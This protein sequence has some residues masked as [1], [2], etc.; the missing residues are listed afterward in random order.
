MRQLSVRL[1]L[2][3]SL[4]IWGRSP[5]FAKTVV[6][7]QDG[8]PTVASEPVSRATLMQAL[9]EDA[10]F[11]GID[12]LRDPSALANADLLVLPYGSAFPAADFS[13]ILGYLQGGGNLLT[14]GG[15]P[16]RVPVT[17]SGAGFQQE[18]PQDTYSL[19]LG[20]RHTYEIP[21]GQAAKFA[22]KPG[23]TFLQ[24]TAIQGRRFF[25][26]EGQVSGLGYMVDPDGTK[27]AAPVVVGERA[28]ISRAPS[29]Q[30]QSPKLAKNPRSAR[31]VT[32]PATAPAVSVSC[33]A[34]NSH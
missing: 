31:G 29:S 12:G 18:R 14:L 23:Y 4:F 10:V 2:L 34:C 9:G 3:S 32:S 11:V 1:L 26:L 13:V 15:Q 16:F 6:F 22:W 17:E 25:A 24:R 28:G 7:W 27:V 8:F 19:E 33:H 5:L 21:V 20:I 30:L